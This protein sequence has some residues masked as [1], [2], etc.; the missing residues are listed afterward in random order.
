MERTIIP[1]NLQSLLTDGAPITLLDVRRSDDRAIGPVA[2]RGRVG[3]TSQPSTPGTP[4]S[5]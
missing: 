3:T 4:N 1:A 2:I 5:I